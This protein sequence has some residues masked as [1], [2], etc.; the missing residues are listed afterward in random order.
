MG[1]YERCSAGNGDAFRNPADLHRHV[2]LDPIGGIQLNL[3]PLKLL[4]PLRLYRKRVL[5]HRKPLHGVRAAGIAV[6]GH[7]GLGSDIEHFD[8]RA[9]DRGAT[10]VRDR[11]EDGGRIDLAH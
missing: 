5:A 9:G 1:C 8:R 6:G 3:F 2:D 11:T 10:R 7:S 4:E